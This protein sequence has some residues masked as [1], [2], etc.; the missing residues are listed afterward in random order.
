RAF[1]GSPGVAFVPQ[2]ET[3]SPLGERLA[4]AGT[5]ATES[6]P[7]PL[8]HH[9]PDKAIRL[10]SSL[11]DAD[12]SV[13]LLE[14]LIKPTAVSAAGPP[15]AER[16]FETAPPSAEVAGPAPG[17]DSEP[18]RREGAWTPAGVRPWAWLAGAGGLAALL[19]VARRWWRGPRQRGTRPVRG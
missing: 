4:S 2:A 19:L 3:Y 5:G 6:A 12:D 1:D 10:A 9:A 11:A 7:E 14:A 18:G 13:A 16:S 15:T 17:P 8:L